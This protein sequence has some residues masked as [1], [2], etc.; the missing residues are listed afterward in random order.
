VKHEISISALDGP[1]LGGDPGSACMGN[2]IGSGVEYARPE[3]GPPDGA[4]AHTIRAAS[5]FAPRDAKRQWA[6]TVTS[7]L[8]QD[9]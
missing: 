3:H 9:A 2:R 1:Y 4:D 8:V 6:N 5:L 7:D